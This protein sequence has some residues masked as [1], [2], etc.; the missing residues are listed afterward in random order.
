MESEPKGVEYSRDSLEENKEG[1]AYD[2]GL[3][4]VDLQNLTLQSC[5]K[6]ADSEVEAQGSSTEEPKKSLQ[7]IAHENRPEN[8]KIAFDYLETLEEQLGDFKDPKYPPITETRNYEVFRDRVVSAPYMAKPMSYFVGDI[9]YD[10]T[11]LSPFPD[12]SVAASFAEYYKQR[13]DIELLEDQPLLS[14]IHIRKRLNLL[15]SRYQNTKGKDL[16]LPDKNSKRYGILTVIMHM[17]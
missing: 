11:P 5:K 16:P 13:Y 14:M 17:N 2:G 1:P 10:M 12:P 6:I 4:D 3:K 15:S 8:L 9:C 7:D